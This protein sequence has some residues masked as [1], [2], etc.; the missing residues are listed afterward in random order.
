[1]GQSMG[2]LTLSLRNL[3]DTDQETTK[4]AT[5]ADLRL[6]HDRLT[7]N[8]PATAEPTAVKAA[9]PKQEPEVSVIRTLRGRYTGRVVVAH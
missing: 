8:L 9:A 1:L 2:A 4:P 7:P 5:L 3:D 6:W